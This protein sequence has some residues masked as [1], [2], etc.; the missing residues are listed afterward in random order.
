[1][2][3]QRVV[4]V[5]KCSQ[6]IWDVTATECRRIRTTGTGGVE[7]CNMTVQS[8]VPHSLR[9]CTGS[10]AQLFQQLST[11]LLAPNDPRRALILANEQGQQ[12]GQAEADFSFGGAPVTAAKDVSFPAAAAAK[13]AK[14]SE[15]SPKG[16]SPSRGRIKSITTPDIICSSLSSLSPFSVLLM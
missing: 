11:N 4:Y 6:T 10:R 3:K 7:H 15:P 8:A 2:A 14:P 12:Q 1:M 13:S 16:S 9:F 5:N